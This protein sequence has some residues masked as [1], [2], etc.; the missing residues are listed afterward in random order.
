VL[1]FER[2]TKGFDARL[3]CDRRRYE[4]ILP[5]AAFRPDPAAK[6]AVSP[7]APGAAQ[8]GGGGADAPAAAAG[9]NSACAEVAGEAPPESGGLDTL[10]RAAAAGD[11]ARAAAEAGAARDSAGPHAAAAQPPAAA[12]GGA[13]PEAGG[14]AP[15]CDLRP[16]EV[17]GAAAPSDGAPRACAAAAPA[18]HTADAGPGSGPEAGRGA[19]EAPLSEAEVAAVNAVLA[20]YEGTHSF[21][22]FTVRMAAGD[23]AAKRF[24]LSFRVAGALSLQARRPGPPP[25]PPPPPPAPAP[26]R[27]IGRRHLGQRGAVHSVLVGCRSM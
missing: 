4:Y 25:R 23:A 7:G 6:P 24:I 26:G 27:G 11:P 12:A 21:H 10:D 13:A 19:R 9:G 17:K 1:G 20:R 15:P 5:A 3:Q 18:A 16:A 14:R 2:V 8:G 22:N